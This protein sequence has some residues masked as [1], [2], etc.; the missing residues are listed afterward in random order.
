MQTVGEEGDEYRRLFLGLVQYGTRGKCPSFC[1]KDFFVTFE[2]WVH[3]YICLQQNTSE[4]SLSE[5]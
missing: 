3:T 4:C 5:Q 2:L 1:C